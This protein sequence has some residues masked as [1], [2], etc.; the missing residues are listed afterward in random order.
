MTPT[1]PAVVALLRGVLEAVVLA[2]IGVLV[3]ALGEIEAGTLAPWAPIG[4]LILRQLE[5][6]A[7]EKIDPTKQRS[8]LGG[9]PASDSGQTGFNLLVVLLVGFIFGVLVCHAGWL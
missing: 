8:P 2:V 1:R 5:G 7:D 4:L 9:G 3:V 6:L